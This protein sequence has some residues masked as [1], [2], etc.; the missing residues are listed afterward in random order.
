MRADGGCRAITLI[1]P[2]G[3]GKSRL[4]RELETTL[5]GEAV[6]A[7]GRCLSY[8]DD[9]AYRPFA[10]MVHQLC[11]A[12]PR[13]RVEELLDGDTARARLV[14]QA[15]G[16]AEGAAKPEETS[17]A[18]RTLLERAAGELPLVVMVDDVHWAEPA[19]LD[20]LDYLLAFSTGSPILLLCLARPEL[21]E[22]RPA[23]MV[24]QPDRDVL[25]LDA[26]SSDQAR[27]LVEPAGLDPDAEARIV[28]LA[29]GNPL[30]LE[31]L[32]AMGVEAGGSTLPSTIQ[33]VLAARIDRLDDRERRALE[34]AAVQGRSFWVDAVAELL[35]ED[36]REGF[37]SRLVA[38]VGKQL[39]RPDRS[40]AQGRN[41]FRFAHALI[42]EVAYG[43]LPKVR[44]A[45][46]HERLARWL[47]TAPGARD[48]TIGFHLA[49]S[50]DLRSELGP[51][52]D[53]EL[54]LAQAAAERLG[55]AAAAARLRGDTAAGARLL[56]RADGLLDRDH[57]GRSA[58][59]PVLG[60]A[61]FE[62]GRPTDAARVLDAAIE[63]APDPGSR[64]CAQVERE[65]VRFETEPAAAASG[66]GRVAD[67]ALRVL[68]DAG[69][70][71]GQC[72]A[73][74]LRGEVD[75]WEGQAGDAEVAWAQASACASRAGDERELFEVLGWR[76]VA[77]ALGPAP[78]PEAIRRCEDFR[79]QVEG[80]PIATA[81]TL[82]P[83]ALLNAMAG[84]LEA[85]DALLAEASGILAEVGGLGA[86]ISHLEASV[87]LLGGRPELAEATLRADLETLASMNVPG[88]LAT[89]TALLAQAV[90]AQGRALEA[91]ELAQEA[92]RGVA[93][94]DTITEVIW[95]GVA[96][97][98]AARA[99]RADEAEKLAREAV[100]LATPTD[101][102][103][104]RGDAMLDL[105]DVL[106]LA[107]RPEEGERSAREGLALYETKGNVAAA[108][109][110]RALLDGQGGG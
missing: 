51:V 7:V 30:F 99:G 78:V 50:Y 19:L 69:D 62:A 87:R 37:S 81:S 86:G 80:S 11:G 22:S 72:R 2:A 27:R 79:S 63:R 45:E 23:W 44:R 108:A 57:A 8:G 84:D 20:L 94:D 74:L 9:I 85:A 104:H 70:H 92:A 73:L 106:W 29:E 91:G 5:E 68:E 32:M 66:A 18:L 13:R 100:A 21:G 82:N 35:P 97:R 58:L 53:H 40:E 103:S 4:A 10:E 102:L 61:L 43:G 33:A 88:T 64:A 95:R 56:A 47:E 49:E 14:L 3:I 6:V 77:A 12:D 1:G 36:E 55:S 75:W 39:I 52:G 34:H 24:P 76:A 38:L 15:I 28:G 16:L 83:L 105:A 89:T 54:G 41:A 101:L 42:R 109:R 60:A 90:L 17:W 31:Q 96:A 48:E 71:R 26:L 107:G 25:V 65:L 110:A 93:Q 98:T 46:L 67:D 59:R